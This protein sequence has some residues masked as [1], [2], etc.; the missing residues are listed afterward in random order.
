M[1][2]RR[3]GRRRPVLVAALG[4][5]VL[6]AAVAVSLGPV[7]GTGGAATALLGWDTALLIGWDVAAATYVAAILV[8]LWSATPETLERRAADLDESQW[9][10]LALS[11]AAAVASLVAVVAD[12]AASR[13][14]AGAG[15]AAVVAGLTVVL[16][17]CF[18]QVL[19]AQHYAHVH[20]LRGGLDFPGN[21]RPDFPEFLYFA[22]TVG[23]TAQVADVTTRTAA[24]RRVVLGHA[25]LSFAFNAVVLAAAVNLAAALVG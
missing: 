7:A 5:G 11:V 17:W 10:I 4:L 22:M 18:V 24:M 23:M 15:S 16:S 6:G 13:G 8:T 1:G 20:L 3:M 2:L 12:L 9:A 14:T 21:D 25:A 19:F